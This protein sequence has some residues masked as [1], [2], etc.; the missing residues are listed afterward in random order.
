[1]QGRPGLAILDWGALVW[2][3]RAVLVKECMTTTYQTGVPWLSEF[4]YYLTALMTREPYDR[5]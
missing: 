2:L 3:A 1:M 5:E 4:W